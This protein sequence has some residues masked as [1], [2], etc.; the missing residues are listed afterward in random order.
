MKIVL[1]S[2]VPK[3]G[4]KYDVKEVSPGYARNFLFPRRLAELATKNKIK[5]FEQNKVKLEDER[6]VQADLL[7]KNFEALKSTSIELKEKTNEKGH[8]FKGIHKEEIAKALKEQAHIDL[9]TD[10][11]DL[12]H[13]I[14]E[15]GEF[16]IKVHIPEDTSKENVTF[17]LTIGKLEEK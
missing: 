3:I 7:Q 2:D 16:D 14:K 5:Y 15:V 6:A 10:N 8:L 11:I 4:H 9:P 12:E 1:L 13:P 17:K